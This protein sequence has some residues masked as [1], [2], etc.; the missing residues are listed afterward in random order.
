MRTDRHSRY[1]RPKEAASTESTQAKEGTSKELQD[2]VDSQQST[3][4][5]L[6]SEK[7]SLSTQLDSA[8]SKLSDLEDRLEESSEKLGQL[9]E[10]QSKVDAL[11]KDLESEKGRKEEVEGQTEEVAAKVRELVRL[12]WFEKERWYSRESRNAN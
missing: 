11:R 1:F 12:L 2:L 8:E 4:N 3:I 6:V 7:S 5:L 10:L 9:A